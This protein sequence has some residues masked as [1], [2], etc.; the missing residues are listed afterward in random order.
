MTA[1]QAST[2]SVAGI[3]TCHLLREDFTHRINDPLTISFLWGHGIK[4]KTR[5]ESKREMKRGNEG[6]NNNMRK[7]AGDCIFKEEEQENLATAG[8]G[9]WHSEHGSAVGN[10]C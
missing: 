8:L 2:H 1:V 10:Y 3:V 4:S 7:K 5:E 9:S 6:G